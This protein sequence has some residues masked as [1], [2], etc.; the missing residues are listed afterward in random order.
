MLKRMEQ[1]IIFTT[2]YGII[3]ILWNSASKSANFGETPH[4][5][6]NCE[7]TIFGVCFVLYR[8]LHYQPPRTLELSS[9]TLGYT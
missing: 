5:H 7:G 1:C 6:N 2:V 8:S 3:Y 9:H 4:L